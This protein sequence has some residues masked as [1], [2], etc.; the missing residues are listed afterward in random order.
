MSL[1]STN[2]TFSDPEKVER[3]KGLFRYE[4]RD[5]ALPQTTVDDM[6]AL[7]ESHDDLQELARMALASDECRPYNR[8]RFLQLARHYGK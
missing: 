8:D 5:P 1:D 3:I 6:K 4:L 7:L 2:A